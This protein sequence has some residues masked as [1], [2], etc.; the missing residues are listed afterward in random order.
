MSEAT[1]AQRE[2]YARLV[3]AIFTETLPERKARELAEAQA[4]ADSKN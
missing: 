3:G 2:A 4:E 1:Q